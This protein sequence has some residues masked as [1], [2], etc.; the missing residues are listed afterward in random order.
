MSQQLDSLRQV[1]ANTGWTN[2]ARAASLEVRRAKAARRQTEQAPSTGSD[3]KEAWWVRAAKQ[4]RRDFTRNDP[5]TPLPAQPVDRNP[6][7]AKLFAEQRKVTGKDFLGNW[8]P[9]GNDGKTQDPRIGVSTA[10]APYGYV[11]GTRTPRQEPLYDQYGRP[12]IPRPKKDW[13]E[14]EVVG[15]GPFAEDFG[16]ARGMVWAD[17]LDKAEKL[18]GEHGKKKRFMDAH[19][20]ATEAQWEAYGEVMAGK[21]RKRKAKADGE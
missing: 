5:P 3:A 6:G 9:R 20:G 4:M 14:P 7:R 11:E 13:F 18:W 12:I 8:Y 1:V 10:E 17:K 2:E 19:P 15:L 21:K 16:L